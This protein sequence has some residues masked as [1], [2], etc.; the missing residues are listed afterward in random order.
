MARPDELEHGRRLDL[1]ERRIH[2]VEQ[3]GASLAHHGNQGSTETLAEGRIGS[4]VLGELVD[5]LAVVAPTVL[6]P[7]GFDHF[8]DPRAELPPA[9]RCQWARI[10]TQVPAQEP[11]AAGNCSTGDL[12]EVV[13]L[14]RH[15]KDCHRRAPLL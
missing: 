7:P 11:I 12:G 13:V 14:G 4:V 3:Q 10:L 9:D 6:R 15:P 2:R 1:F 5:P 8:L